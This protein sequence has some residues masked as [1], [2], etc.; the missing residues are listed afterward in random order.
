[1]H[2]AARGRRADPV[3]GMLE[4]VSCL[5]DRETRVRGTRLTRV[6]I[7]P[8]IADIERRASLQLRRTVRRPVVSTPCCKQTHCFRCAPA[9]AGLVIAALL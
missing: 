6:Q 1:M 8:T 5:A 3:D 9:H 7:I 2:N 4:R